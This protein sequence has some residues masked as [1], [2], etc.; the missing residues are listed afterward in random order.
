MKDDQDEG[1]KEG[2]GGTVMK[3]LKGAPLREYI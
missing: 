2:R 1:D 3:R